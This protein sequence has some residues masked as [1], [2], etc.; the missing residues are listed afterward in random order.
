MRRATFTYRDGKP[1]IFAITTQLNQAVLSSFL[2][3]PQKKHIPFLSL[4]GPRPVIAIG[5]TTVP[6][7]HVPHNESRER[8]PKKRE[9]LAKLERL[10][11]TFAFATDRAALLGRFT[12]QQVL[13]LLVIRREES[14]CFEW[15]DSVRPREFS[16]SRQGGG[17]I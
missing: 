11:V 1:P 7:T 9:I 2:H 10:D 8:A 14:H 12:A 13:N 6:H 5:N 3:N 16:H 17:T 15:T 4:F